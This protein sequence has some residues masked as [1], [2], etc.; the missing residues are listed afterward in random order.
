MSRAYS[1]DVDRGSEV[2]LV[3][4]GEQ[5]G[6]G[7]RREPVPEL[8]ADLVAQVAQRDHDLE[9]VAPGDALEHVDHS[10]AGWLPTG[11]NGQSSSS[12]AAGRGNTTPRRTDATS[13]RIA[14]I[15]AWSLASRTRAVLP[16]APG[17]R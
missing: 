8:L 17:A 11:A 2:H 9:P 6:P 7:L 10:R 3:E 13:A 12:C 5:E 14:S 15:R 4:A 16:A 1:R